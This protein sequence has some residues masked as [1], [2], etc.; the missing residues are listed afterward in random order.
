MPGNNRKGISLEQAC[1]PEGVRIYAIGDVHGRLDLLRKM[2]AAIGAEGAEVRDWRIVHLGDYVDRGPQSREVIDFLIE[3]E[4]DPRITT[5]CGNHD[6]GMVDFLATPDAAGLFAR[7]G[8]DATARS[9]GVDLLFGTTEEFV[10]AHAAFE[11][12]VPQAHR[13]FLKGLKFWVEMGDFFFC[14]AGIRPGVPLDKQDPTDLIWIRQAFH[15]HAGLHPKVI[16][17][18]H[19]PTEQPELLPNRVNV[20]TGAYFS[21]VLTALVIEGAEK[22]ILQVK[23]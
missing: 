7:Y 16:V 17:H 3:A 19:T 11:R 15:Y 18:G 6:I 2:Y 9:Y 5:L 21:G 20:D 23:G 4:Q 1:G 22:R 14:H 12:A 13:D 8:G 10:A